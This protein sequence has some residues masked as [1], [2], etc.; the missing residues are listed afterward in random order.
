MGLPWKRKG[1]PVSF[2]YNLASKALLL[3]ALTLCASAEGEYIDANLGVSLDYSRFSMEGGVYLDV[4]LMVPRGNFTF[5]AAAPGLEAQVIFQASLLQGDVEAYPSDRW[6]RKYLAKNEEEVNSLGFVADITKFYVEA[7]DYT[8]QLDILDVNSRRRQRIL[9]QVSLTL[10]PENELSI[11]DLTLAS[12]INRTDRETEFTKYGHDIVPNAEGVYSL[13]API[14]Y[15]YFEAYGLSE[16]GSYRVHPQ[17]LSISGDVVKNYPVQTK[18]IPGESIVE[19]G[20]IN[21]SGLKA[22]IHKLSLDFV[23]LNSG[24][25]VNQKKT[26]YILRPKTHAE[27]QITGGG[28]YSSMNEAQLDGIFE[29]VSIAMNENEIL[30][31]EQ[32]GLEG[33]QRILTTFWQRNDTNPETNVNEFKNDFY[34]RVQLADKEYGT[35]KTEGWKTD[36][37]RVLLQYGKPNNMERN[38]SGIGERPYETWHYYDIEGGIEFV[39]VDGTG[40]GNYKLVHSTARNE[41]HD[42][43]WDRLLK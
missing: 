10:F 1:Y 19:W 7:G 18:A 5:E 33:K 21:T 24:D 28:T 31:F 23:D 32:S 29:L 9:Q 13:K 8:L 43:S 22:G 39:F 40:Y 4:Y 37:G 17:I 30:L 16:T 14:L 2:P 3:L 12:Q 15:Y 41:I 26:F 6:E 20:G 34:N 11:S 42:R 36:R 35:D 27:P 38:H 25:S